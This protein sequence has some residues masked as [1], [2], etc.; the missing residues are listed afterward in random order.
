M[1][2]GGETD[3]DVNAG[4]KMVQALQRVDR[5]RGRL[6]DIDETLVRPDLEVLA[7]ILVLERRTDHAVHVLFGWERHGTGHGRA[8]ARRR[9]DDLLRR[10]LDRRMVVA[11]ETDSNFV[12]G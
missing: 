2:L 9:I 8:G 3:L 5:L 7:R 10:R 6:V 12:L 11:L 4:R 1:V